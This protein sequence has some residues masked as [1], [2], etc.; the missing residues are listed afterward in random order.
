MCSCQHVPVY[1]YVDQT[2]YLYILYIEE[3]KNKLNLHHSLKL[4]CFKGIL[5]LQMFYMLS[6][7][8]KPFTK[9]K[10]RQ[11]SCSLRPIPLKSVG[12][13]KWLPQSA[14]EDYD[15]NQK[16]SSQRGSCVTNPYIKAPRSLKLIGYVYGKL[17]STG[18]FLLNLRAEKH[19]R[20]SPQSYLLF[21]GGRNIRLVRRGETVASQPQTRSTLALLLEGMFC[22]CYE[23]GGAEAMHQGR[24]RTT[25]GDPKAQLSS[26]DL[27][28]PAV[29]TAQK[30]FSPMENCWEFS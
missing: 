29:A 4:S 17:Y 16:S 10:R 6:K 11:I 15:S 13:T 22:C 26:L 14:T 18:F 3:Y 23:E 2:I 19:H 25:C 7:H 9:R 20:A 24:P 5:H 30:S 21:A 1:R 27:V 12:S 8:R 28:G